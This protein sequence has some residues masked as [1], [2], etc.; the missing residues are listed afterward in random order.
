MGMS[1]KSRQLKKE[2]GQMGG[3]VDPEDDNLVNVEEEMVMVDPTTGLPLTEE[4]KMANK[5]YR[6]KV[7]QEQLSKRPPTTDVILDPST[8]MAMIRAGR[9]VL[10]VVTRKA[11]KLYDDPRLRLAQMFPGV[12]PQTRKKYRMTDLA[13][14]G[15]QDVINAFAIAAS[16]KE[17]EDDELTLPTF[18]SI[19]SKALDWVIS[20]WDLLGIDFTAALGRC[21]M[22]GAYKKDAERMHA[23][24]DLTRHHMLIENYISGPFKQF[25]NMAEERIGP[26]FGDLDMKAYCSGELYERC[27]NY[28]VLKSMQCV[29]ETKVRDAERL[30]QM[31]EDMYTERL[32]RAATGDPRR[33]RQNSDIITDLGDCATICARAQQMVQEFVKTPELFDDLPVE[34]RFLEAAL[35]IQGGTALRKFMIEDFC[36][37]EQITPSALIEGMR[38]FLRLLAQSNPDPYGPLRKIV[39]KLSKAMARGSSVGDDIEP[40][41]AYLDKRVL[42]PESPAFFQT[43]TFNHHPKGLVKY[44][45]DWKFLQTPEATVQNGKQDEEPLFVDEKNTIQKKKQKGGGFFQGIVETFQ[46]VDPKGEYDRVANAFSIEYNSTY[47]PPD[48]RS[49]GRPHEP[50]M[51]WFDD[52]YKLEAFYVGNQIDRPQDVLPVGMIEPGRIILSK[53]EEEEIAAQ[54]QQR[55]VAVAAQQEADVSAT[56]E[57]EEEKATA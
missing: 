24:R 20:N 26:N 47:I 21:M 38:R 13:K 36:P 15:P 29:W 25:C 35:K 51:D 19:A 46:P 54:Q 16:I 12:P 31:D 34:L 30:N 37:K 8:Q 40:L 44:L 28:I 39:Y 6:T 9:N 14:M 49:I 5:E 17:T 48:A 3:G 52:L 32:I 42:D 43:Y 7:I 18:P 45:D 50:D 22:N 1:R 10:D 23:Y 55:A 2:M 4:E 27:A 33:F 41:R 53:E 57:E 56:A 11:V